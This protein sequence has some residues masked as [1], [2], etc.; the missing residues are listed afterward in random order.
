MINMFL[1]DPDDPRDRWT[2]DE[3]DA[4]TIPSSMTLEEAENVLQGIIKGFEP[5][6]RHFAQ[7]LKDSHITQVEV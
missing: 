4:F 6:E 5:T 1:C 7:Q 2:M 3:G